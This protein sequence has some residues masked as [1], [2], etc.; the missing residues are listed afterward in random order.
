MSALDSNWRIRAKFQGKSAVISCPTN[1]TLS[2]LEE[3]IKDNEK[4]GLGGQQINL[5]GGFPPVPLTQDALQNSMNITVVLGQQKEQTLSPTTATAAAGGGASSA[6]NISFIRRIVHADN[7]CLFTALAFLLRGDR[8]EGSKLRKVISEAVLGDTELY[9]DAMLGK[10]PQEY[11]DWIMNSE[12]WGGELEL[13]ILS[14]YF[15]AEI[16]AVEVSTGNV[17]TYGEGEGHANRCYLLYDGAHYD[18]LCQGI[19]SAP[20][21]TDKR[22]FDASP[23]SSTAA[24]ERA[25]AK[26]VARAVKQKKQFISVGTADLRC[27]QCQQ[28][29]VGQAGAQAHASETGH[30]NFGKPLGLT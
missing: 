29:L 7:S 3:C 16:A 28:P 14:K 27:L 13:F 8:A 24:N 18:P 11:S 5:L 2:Q 1:C 30:V 15:Q 25:A 4:L 20:E 22:V 23:T 10:P 19:E 26:A 6:G 21:S 12:S 17:Y 9:S